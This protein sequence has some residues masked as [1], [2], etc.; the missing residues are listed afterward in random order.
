MIWGAFLVPSVFA[1]APQVIVQQ[2]SVIASTNYF[3]SNQSYFT[4]SIGRGW[5]GTTTRAFVTASYIVNGTPVNAPIQLSMREFSDAS[6]SSLIGFCLFTSP[7]TTG[8]YPTSPG[9]VQLDFVSCSGSSTTFNS[10]SYYQIEIGFNR[11]PGTVDFTEYRGAATNTTPYPITWNQ[12]DPTY[13]NF[14]PQFVLVGGGFQITPT[15]GDTGLLMSGAQ[16]FC[17]SQFGTSSAG[18]FGIGTDIANGFCQVAGYLFIP[19]GE[20]LQQFS[21]LPDVL[22]Q[23][24][25]FSYMYQ[26][27]LSFQGLAAS[28]TENMESFSISGLGTFASTSPFSSVIPSSIDIISTST[29]SKYYPDPIRHTMLF[30]ASSA[31]WF[32][33][34][35]AIY[36]R[37]VPHKMT[38]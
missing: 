28:S 33:L 9:Y 32:V 12:T 1:Q 15:T 37:I 2:S 18:V 35:L 3:Q 34:I 31:I 6:Y 21:G 23:R 36:H 22:G 27:A 4:Y 7:R 25:P 26:F 24:I 13:P 5:T 30:L 16:T 8:A 38:I 19:T 10:S 14:A 29:I 17:N 11:Q 20:S